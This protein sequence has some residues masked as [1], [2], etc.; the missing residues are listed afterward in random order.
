MSSFLPESLSD[1][2]SFFVLVVLEVLP[3][4]FRLVGAYELEE[5]VVP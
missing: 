1:E 3:V 4:S 5:D 2:V